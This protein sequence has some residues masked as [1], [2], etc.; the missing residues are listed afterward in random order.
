[1][2][3]RSWSAFSVDCK[4]KKGNKFGS[5]ELISPTQNSS[6]KFLKINLSKII[7]HE[8]EQNCLTKVNKFIE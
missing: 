1:V 4:H 2:S 8:D 3:V 7:L 6:I 5:W